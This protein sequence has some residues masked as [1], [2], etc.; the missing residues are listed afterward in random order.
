MVQLCIPTL[1][2]VGRKIRVGGGE[3]MKFS[4]L[5]KDENKDHIALAWQDEI[6]Q[7][8][9]SS[10]DEGWLVKVTEQPTYIVYHRLR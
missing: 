7:L 5:N 8:W 9:S 10:R 1:S 3:T 6:S 2:S 4:C